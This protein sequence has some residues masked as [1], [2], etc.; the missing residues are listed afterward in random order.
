MI[1]LNRCFWRQVR[2]FINQNLDIYA[3]LTSL[4]LSALSLEQGNSGRALE[5]ASSAIPIIS[6]YSYHKEAIAA[7]AILQEA[8]TIQSID[9][10]VIKKA[11]HH[12]ELVRTDPTSN[13]FL[14]PKS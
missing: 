2:G 10:R 1:L 7:L 3:A 12:L 11:L 6:Q 5:M 13:F 14:Q 9:K 4:E 8:E